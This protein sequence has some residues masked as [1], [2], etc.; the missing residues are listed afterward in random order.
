MARAQVRDVGAERH[1]LLAAG[2]HDAGVAELD[3]LGAQRHGAKAG[4]THL[5][6]AP[7]CAFGRQ[8][9]VHMGLAGRVLALAAG[10]HLAE[11]RLVDLCLVDACALNQLFEHYGAQIVGRRARKRAVE[12]AHG[13]ACGRN[14][15]DVGHTFLSM[16]VRREAM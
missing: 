4:A 12:T 8:A 11:D 6:D 2:H 5:V 1:V 7:G 13:R 14:D 10:E 9:G 15:N 3:V 16:S